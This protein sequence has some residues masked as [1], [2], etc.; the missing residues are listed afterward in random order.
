MQPMRFW[1]LE[2]GC[3]MDVHCVKMTYI[4]GKQVYLKCCFIFGG[5][6]IQQYPPCGI[7]EYFTSLVIIFDRAH[8]YWNADTFLNLPDR[9]S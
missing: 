9:C 1:Q 8:A 3:V 4:L 5:N 2:K 7:L 6:R